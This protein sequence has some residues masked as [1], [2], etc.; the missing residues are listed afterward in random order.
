MPWACPDTNNLSMV[1]GPGHPHSVAG[2]AF[3]LPGSAVQEVTT[4]ARLGR[5]C[6]G[7][8]TRH[9]YAPAAPDHRPSLSQ[10]ADSLDGSCV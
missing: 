2:T 9:R 3:L 1:F 10:R 7:G 8:R 6:K 5:G 4:R